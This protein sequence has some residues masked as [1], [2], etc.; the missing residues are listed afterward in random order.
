MR[1]QIGTDQ[2]VTRLEHKRYSRPKQNAGLF[3][4][5]YFEIIHLY[6]SG[7]CSSEMHPATQVT[8]ERTLESSTM[9]GIPGLVWSC[10]YCCLS[11]KA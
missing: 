4:C 3:P 9:V 8:P 10:R 6:P 2:A 1:V 11:A 7:S 5:I